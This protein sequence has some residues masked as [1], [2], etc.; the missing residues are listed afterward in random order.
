[1]DNELRELEKQLGKLTPTSMPDDMIMRMENAMQ[2]WQ[3]HLPAEEKIVA[4][5]PAAKTHDSHHSKLH[6][7][8]IAASAAAVVLLGAVV[9]M[10]NN[11]E[12]ADPAV[13]HKSES[14]HS[15]QT[16]AP[17]VSSV[18]K[19]GVALTSSP[20]FNS[21]IQGSSDGTITYD[22]NGRP[23]RLVSVQFMDEGKVRDAEG[24]I[25]TIKKPR[26]EYYLVPVEVH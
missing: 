22:E 26:T 25:I 9:V 11:G 7:F 4:F 21:A 12:S 16:A 15:A 13:A 8:N 10:I 3:H 14:S 24:R 23:M 17:V 18:P 2:R 20:Q 19:N 1:M 6:F 5:H